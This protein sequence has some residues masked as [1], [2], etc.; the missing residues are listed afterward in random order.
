MYGF[1][2]LNMY[3]AK[4][5]TEGTYLLIRM[6]RTFPELIRNGHVRNLFKNK[7]SF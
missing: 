7:N 1:L 6:S 3:M 4:Y 2:F 5:K